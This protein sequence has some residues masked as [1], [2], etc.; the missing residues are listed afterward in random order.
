[1]INTA[2][3]FASERFGLL[4]QIAMIFISC[5]SRQPNFGNGHAQMYVQSTH[6]TVCLYLSCF[7]SNL[8]EM[9]HS[10]LE[11]RENVV[12]TQTQQTENLKSIGA[13][14]ACLKEERFCAASG[15]SPK[16][17]KKSTVIKYLFPIRSMLRLM[18]RAE[19]GST[20]LKDGRGV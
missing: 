16:K 13:C 19:K 6:F 17:K 11:L 1:M 4:M 20:Q 7:S 9:P 18:F 2:L 15:H 14:F 10:Q 8:V 5:C 3:F 12:K